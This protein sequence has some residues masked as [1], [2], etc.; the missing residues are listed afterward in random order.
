M[1]LSEITK[2]LNGE[3]LGEGSAE[4]VR[5]AKI[6]EAEPGD[7]TFLANP[8]YKKYLVSTKATA[9]LIASDAH[10][11]EVKKRTVPLHLIKV[12]DPYASF[13][14]LIERFHPAPIPL[15][16]GIHASALIAPTARL[17][18]NI[19]IGA[20]VVIGEQCVIGDGV[21]IYHGSVLFD[22]VTIGKE[23][24]LYANVIIREQCKIGNQ[25]IIHSGTVIGSDGFGFAPK[26]DGTYEKIP[27]RGIVVIEDDVEIG[28][29]CTIDRATIGE[30]KIRQ[31]A[32]LDNLI[33]IAHN[34]VIGEN[35]V[36]A[37]QTGISGSTKIGKNCILAGQ[38]G[39]VGH[40]E[41]ADRIT[42]GAQSGVSKSLTES[43]KVYFGSPVKELQNTLRLEVALRQL[44]EL[45]L[46][47]RKLELRCT[48]LEKSL[49]Q[50]DNKLQD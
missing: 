27:Q 45:L 25:V 41:I 42:I 5:V 36:I 21:T 26:Q 8:K 20:N 38:V 48:E 32:K 24:L 33:Q 28:A 11:E 17:G 4:I 19:A 39:I 10:F 13:L 34:V 22:D 46:E 40:V 43:G 35:T 2:Q 6:E 29:N 47:F 16:K 12:A 18:S 14:K 30:T 37:G 44:P 3:L 23:S 15:P 9:I 7:I 1:T 50:S 49:K 31:G